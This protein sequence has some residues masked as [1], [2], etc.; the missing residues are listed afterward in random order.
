MLLAYKVSL[1]ADI[2]K[3]VQMLF[4]AQMQNDYI[5]EGSDNC[6]WWKFKI[7]I[8]EQHTK[9][10]KEHRT[11]HDTCHD[12]TFRA[13]GLEIVSDSDFLAFFSALM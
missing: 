8:L 2:L 7:S 6:Q 13:K 10:R 4:K 5:L 3:N 11:W 9:L 1:V 12:K